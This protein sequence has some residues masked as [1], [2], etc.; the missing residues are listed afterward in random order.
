[1][2]LTL[3]QKTWALQQAG[4]NP[5][6]YDLDDEGFATLKVSRQPSV[7]DNG[8]PQPVVSV[9]PSVMSPLKT[10]G[11]TF[12]EQAPAAITGGAAFAGASAPLWAPA[13]ALAPETFGLSL[14]APLFVGGAASLGASTLTKEIQDPIQEKI[15]PEATARL[16]AGQAANP[17]SALAGTVATMPLAGMSPSPVN[18]A[19]AGRTALSLA[20]RMGATAPEVANLASVGAGAIMAPAQSAGISLLTGEPLDKKRL[21]EEAVLGAMF[22]RPNAI[23]RKYGFPDANVPQELPDRRQTLAAGKAAPRPIPSVGQTVETVPSGAP[24]GYTSMSPIDVINRV[25]QHTGPIVRG[26]KGVEKVY[27]RIGEQDLLSAEEAA[28]APV[29]SRVA[30]EPEA[31]V[32]QADLARS[33]ANWELQKAY[34]ERAEADRTKAAE[35]DAANARAELIKAQVAMRKNQ[36]AQ[37]PEVRTQPLA[38]TEQGVDIM[39]DYTGVMEHDQTQIDTFQDEADAIQQRLE[40]RQAEDEGLQKPT[41]ALQKEVQEGLAREKISTTPSP[42]WNNLFAAFGINKRGVDTAKTGVNPAEIGGK[43]LTTTSVKDGVKQVAIQLADSATLDTAPHEIAGHVFLNQLKE[44]W[45]AKQQGKPYEKRDAAIYDRARKLAEASP[46]YQAM[47]AERGW[48]VDEFLASQQGLEYVKQKVLSKEGE[49]RSW[50]NTFKAHI[51]QVYGEG[52]SEADIRRLLLHR[53]ETDPV[54]QAKKGELTGGGVTQ[55]NQGPDEGLIPPGYRYVNLVK[56]DGS[57]ERV[58]FNDQYYEGFAHR[59]AS[60]ARLVG[61]KLSHGASGKGERIEEIGATQHQGEDEGLPTELPEVK[62]GE[63][64]PAEIKP[65]KSDLEDS[66]SDEQMTRVMRAQKSEQNQGEDEGLFTTKADKLLRSSQQRT[67]A[68]PQLLATLKNQLSP[69]EWDMLKQAGIEK[70]LGAGNVTTE[71]ARQWIRENGPRAEVHTYGMEGKVSEAKR[72]Y[73]RMTH[74]WYENLPLEMQRSIAN[75]GARYNAFVTDTQMRPEFRTAEFINKANEYIQLG[76]K[77]K[78]EG[79]DTS[80]R[81]TSYYFT[82]SALPTDKPMPEWTATKSGKNVQRVDVVVPAERADIAKMRDKHQ[83]YSDRMDKGEKLTTAEQ[84]DYEQNLNELSKHKNPY[85]NQHLWQP[86]NLHENLPNTLGWAMVQYTTGP[87]GEKIAVIAEAQSRWGQ[88]VRN[89]KQSEAEIQQ[90]LNNPRVTLEAGTRRRLEHTPDHPLLRDYNRLILKAAIEQ[91]HKEGATHIAISD[92]P[93]AMLT[94]HL[95]SQARYVEKKF[96]TEQEAEAALDRQLEDMASGNYSAPYV[97]KEN[98]DWFVRID[99]GT[100]NAL[101]GVDVLRK[102][103]YMLEREAGF[104]HNYDI[105]MP[106][107]AEE[108]TGSKGEVVSL[109]EHKNAFEEKPGMIR[110]TTQEGTKQPRQNLIFRNPDGTPKTTVTARLYPL[111]NATARLESGDNFTLFNKWQRSDEGLPSDPTAARPVERSVYANTGVVGR[112]LLSVIAP[113]VEKVR[114]LSPVAGDA[115]ENFYR[116]YS[117]NLGQFEQS[118]L[119]DLR[120]VRPNKPWKS[121]QDF[122]DWIQQDN[123]DFKAVADY[124]DAIQDGEE[125]P[126]LT[127]LQQRINDAIQK[128]LD[129]T[130]R[131]LESRAGLA[132][133]TLG[134]PGYLPHTLSR[135]AAQEIFE[136][137]KSDKTAQYKRDLEQHYRDQGASESEIAEAWKFIRAAGSDEKANIAEQFG[138]IDKLEGYGLPKSMRESNLLDRMS[139]FNRRYARR[140][141]YYDTIDP[142]NPANKEASEAFFGPEGVETTKPGKNVLEDI[143]G[144]REHNEAFRNAVSGVIR[145]GM[146]GPLTGAKDVITAQTLGLQH[147]D[148]GQI[149]PAKLSALQNFKENLRKASDKGII[150]MNIAGL[151][152]GDGGLRNVINVLQRMRDI[153][154]VVQGRQMLET[155]SRVM[156]FGEGKY[157]AN[158]AINAMREGRLSGQKRGFLEDFVPEWQKYKTEAPTDDVLNEAAARYVEAVQGQYDYRGLPSLAMK[159]T[160]APYAALARWNIEKFNNFT[161][162]V[163]DP[164]INGNIK[165]FLMATLGMVIGG[166]AT[167]K[168]VEEITGRKQ[169]TPTWKEVQYSKNQKTMLAYKMAGLASMAGYAGVLGDTV[170]I[171]FDK[172]LGNRVQAWNN[173]LIEGFNTL[174]QDG[175]FIA[176]AAAKGELDSVVDVMHML[177]QDYVQAYRIM[178]AHAG[179]ETKQE[180]E[181]ANKSRD[182]KLFNQANDYPV[183][184]A[185]QDRPNPLIDRDMKKFK[186]TGDLREAAA[187]LPALVQHALEVSEGNPERLKAE[188]LKLKLNNYSTMPSPESQ[189]LKFSKYYNWLGDTQSGDVAKDRVRDF[190]SQRAANRVKSQMVP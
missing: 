173:P 180:I 145:A 6:E 177:L 128:N 139:R 164:A 54:Y 146:L 102:A 16:R 11:G 168:L 169:K 108:L 144:V 137:P 156:N 131:E 110:G 74:E 35:L 46:E 130:K 17:Y 36:I 186:Q 115:A 2:P 79:A 134:K 51:K 92:M 172:A 187:N 25:S 56:A 107:I 157:L 161:K 94:E 72:E 149:L 68:G 47:A 38:T 33:R 162:Y 87:K 44:H 21:L 64:L 30:L 5:S 104:K 150:R 90:V 86:D 49:W 165:P 82:V 183:S 163:V 123:A 78:H 129:A 154:N 14:L 171:G 83:N 48:D 62:P 176:E 73:D 9:Q 10:V 29:E 4:Y 143:Y 181:R 85:L 18:V 151:E 166:A 81:A 50:W 60:I 118:L 175:G 84:A 67:F 120:D 190:I 89:R 88:E 135:T 98:G 28:N 133:G 66:M 142:T 40:Q 42:E 96:A 57:K 184:P 69:A 112:G 182:L 53:F 93:S 111:D 37:Q 3:E 26:D 116:T 155:T 80:P 39:P 19:K 119:R 55:Q 125:P 138:P 140:L 7:S 99:K 141:A 178:A 43:G 185:S 167:T 188:L 113:E 159:G 13:A 109:G 70:S 59:P 122:V 1:M 121:W 12:L 152:T 15:A 76:T 34:R 132:H 174:V 75:S 114:A 27:P 77:V 136:H 147:Q 45:L 160:F 58:L 91:A 124:R 61:D 153:T 100:W 101:G 24:I 8:F 23:G 106:K 71:Q 52:G 127:P 170:K 31:S 117:R 65:V 148:L 179:S 95:D 189:P 63:N 158:D 97:K 22:N 32:A 126:T 103:G 105:S 41:T 20:T